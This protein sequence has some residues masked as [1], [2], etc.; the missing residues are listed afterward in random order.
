M[1]QNILNY[2]R[3]NYLNKVIEEKDLN[4]F[5]NYI[6]RN[7]VI[8]LLKEIIEDKEKL[9]EI[10]KRSY[11]HALGFD[12]IVLIV[13]KSTPY[14]PELRLHLWYPEANGVP[15]VESL[16][17]HSFNFISTVL[18]GHL[19]NQMFSLEDLNK[20]DN[21]LLNKYIAKL[22]NLT[23]E[24][25]SFIN[26]QIE[27]LEALNLKDFGSEQFIKM[28]LEKTY[29]KQKAI[30]LLDMSEEEWSKLCMYEGHFVS[31]RVSGEKKAYKHVFNKHV[32]LL[33]YNVM[34]INKNEY[35]FH[36]YQKPHRLYYDNKVLNSTMLIT[37]R[38]LENPQG[39]SLQRP[40]YLEENEKGYE[41]IP[42]SVELLKE[43]LINYINFLENKE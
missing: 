10:S 2:L 40:S 42:L 19:E 37:T 8:E 15:L 33:P 6:N 31:N 39:G 5:K 36:P 1:Y 17:E 41:K 23:I 29:Q 4:S 24:E 13:D 9:E 7:N 26:S 14:K 35:Y 28:G 27:I 43:K 21:Q 34:K 30:N 18:S 12:K 38:I 20:E 3:Q 22:S 32:K 16:H 25:K 11:T